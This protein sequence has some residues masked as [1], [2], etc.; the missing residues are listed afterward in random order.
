MHVRFVLL[1]VDRSQR[2]PTSLSHKVLV[3]RL[4]VEILF[5]LLV[6][7]YGFHDSLV[8]FAGVVFAVAI[9]RYGRVTVNLLQIYLRLEAL[10][11]TCYDFWRYDRL[12]ILVA[13]DH[14]LR[15]RLENL[16][17]AQVR[18][19]LVRPFDRLVQNSGRFDDLSTL[20]LVR[21]ARISWRLH[22]Q[23][24]DRLWNL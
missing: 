1:P 7:L 21:A 13:A 15:R 10:P 19:A 4:S 14:G 18:P 9:A 22:H 3:E 6:L 11:H 16:A 5:L 17:A 12:T 20:A 2:I 23:P 8:L 24:V